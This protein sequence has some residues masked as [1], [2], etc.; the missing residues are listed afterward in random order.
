MTA[1]NGAAL[2]ALHFAWAGPTEPGAPHYRAGTEPARRV[3]QHPAR[4]QPRTLRLARPRERLRPGRSRS[5]PAA[6]PPSRPTQLFGD[7]QD[8]PDAR[9]DVVLVGGPVRHRDPHGGLAPPRRA[10]H[11][12]G[13]VPPHRVEKRTGPFVGAVEAHQHLVEHDFVEYGH[14]VG[15]AEL[16]GESAGQRAAPVHQ[17]R[18]PAAA[19]RPQRRVH[20]EA[21]RPAGELWIV[22]E[23][24]ALVTV[25]MNQVDGPH[26][27]RRRVRRRVG[28]E[29][30][31]GVVRDVEPLVRVGGP[32]VGPLD[33]G[34]QRP[35]RR[36]G[37]RP[38]PEGAI[39]VDPRPGLVGQVD[40]R[41]ERVHRTGVDVARLGAHDRR[42]ARARPMTATPRRPASGPGRRPARRRSRRSRC[43]GT[44]AP[45]RW[46]RAGRHRRRR[47]W[48]ARRSARASR[49]STR[50]GAA[51]RAGPPPAR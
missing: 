50:R 21:A 49:R 40:D 51:P 17:R 36:T 19:Q 22:V 1:Y 30:Q 12:A 4:R 35:P 29:D 45:G 23:L 43:P 11:E 44:A 20:G 18:D 28:A 31:A 7:L 41:R 2:D 26:A 47:G 9:V 39:D 16:V 38:H 46:C 24:V 25:G 5:A 15:S 42:A 13:A 3:G 37:R 10:A 32:R 27:H 6:P 33:A 14:A 34:Q 8:G 48:A